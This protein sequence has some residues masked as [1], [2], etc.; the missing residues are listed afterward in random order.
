M[1]MT[2]EIVLG[3]MSTYGK[4]VYYLVVGLYILNI[5]LTIIDVIL[6]HHQY[7]LYKNIFIRVEMFHN[8]RYHLYFDDFPEKE[9]FLDTLNEQINLGCQDLISTGEHFKSLHKERRYIEKISLMQ[10]KA[11][12]MLENECVS[13]LTKKDC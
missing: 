6:T 3:N 2:V 11:K 10:E 4:I 7:N 8:V 12:E 13:Y 9:N 5:I 1:D